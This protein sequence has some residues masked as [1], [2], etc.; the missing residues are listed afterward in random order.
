M[1]TAHS[2][3]HEKREPLGG[4]QYGAGGGGGGSSIEEKSILEQPPPPP[5]PP[6]RDPSDPTISAKKLPKKRKF[7]P[8]ELE[9]MD[10]ISNVTSNI[11]NMV[12]IRAPNMPLGQSGLVQQSTLATRQSPQQQ[13]SDCYQISSGHSVV[14]LPPQSTAVDYSLREEPL[15]SRPRPATVAIDLS[16]WRDHRVLALRDSY[17]YPGVIRNV[18]QG[19]I[20]IEF[21]GERKLVRYTDVLGTGRYDVIGDASPSVGQVTLDAKVCIRCPTSNNHIDAAKVFV[22][23]TVCKILTKPKRFVVKI[24][25]EDDQ[26][27][28]YV[29]K[30][31]DLRLV[32][33]PWWDE[34]EEGLEDCDSSRVEGIDNVVSVPEH[35]YRNSSEAPTAVP[36]LQL[37]HTS[38][39]T[40]HI[41]THSDTSGYY[42]TTGTSPLMTLGTS[43]HSASIALSNGN[44]P[45][46]DLESEDDLDR[47]DITFPSDAGSSKRS[48]MQSR[49]STSSLVEQRSITPRSQA[50]TPRS[51]AATPH[52]YKKGDVVATPSGVRKKFNGKQWRRLCSKEGCSKESQRRGYCS[53]HLSLKGSGL[54]GPTNTF[55]GGRMDGE[56]TSRD[57]DT[58]PNYGDR[59]IAGRF[60]QDETEAANMLV[61]LGSSRSA[62]PAF[63][64][65]TGQ[66]SISPCINQSPVPPLGLN[67][68]N[69]FMPISSPAHHAPPLISPGAKWKHSPTQS[70]FLTQYQQQVIKPEPNRVVRS[71]RPAPTAPVP[72]SIGTSVIRISPVSRGMPG[73]NLTLSWSEQSP[74][75]RHPSVVTTMAQQQ[76]QGIILQHA[77]TTNNSFPNHS[78]ISE[79]NSQIL[80]QSHSPHIPLSAPTPQN[81][82][83]LHKPL[84]Q[85]V[86]YAPQPQNQPIY[87]MQ[88]QHEKKYLVIK[89]SMDVATTGHITN[90]DDKYRSGLINHL[91]QLPP[92]LH[93]AQCQPPQSPAVSS[94]HI[95]KLSVLQQASKVATHV[96]TH[97]DMQRSQP[98]PTSVV[99]TT[100]TEAS[101]PPTP[102]SVFQ[103]VIVQP[104]HL[105]Q[106]PKTQPTREENS[107]NNG[108]LYGSHDVPPVYQP[109]PPSLLNN[110]V[111]NWK[112]AFSW[113]TTVLEQTEVSPPP[114][115]LSPPLSAPPIPISMST[116]GE[117][118]P[119]PGP[120]PITPAEEEDDD[121]F[122]A[123]P[124]TP[125]EVEANANKRRSQSLSALHSK[126]PQSPLKN[127]DR[128]RR[129]MN[130]FMI[131]SKR[132]RAVVHQRH[133]NQDNRTVSKILGEW[134]YAL[135]PEEKQKYHDLASEVKEAHF[136]AHPDWKWCS[137]DRRKSST[138]SFKGSE[139]RGK[140]NST[141]EE[142]DMGPPTDDVPLTPRATDEITVPVTT[143]YN[144][145]PTVEIINQSHTHRIMEIAVPVEDPEPDLKQE[146]DGNASDEDQMVI[147]E[148]PQPEI[149]LKC[150][151]KLTDS[152]N[153]VQD[154]DGEKKYAQPRFSPV[155]GQKR[156][157]TVKQEVT[158]RPKPI[159]AR[160]PSTGIETTTKYHHTPMDKGG[161]V[162]VLSSTY[163]YHSPVNPT[164][165]S[166]FQP[167]GGAFITMPIS[168][169]VIKPEPVKTEQQYSTQY[170]M[171][172]L[173][174]SI[175]ENGR[176]MPKFTAAP[177]LHSCGSKSMMALFKQQQ[178]L[179]SLGTILRPLTSAVPYQ[180]SFT[181]T[182]LDN[183]LVAVSKP[184][185]GSQ[186]LGPTPPHPR[187]YCGFH[188]PISDAGNRNIPAQGLVSGNK[189][190][191]QSVIVS[192]PYSVSTTSTTSTYRGIGHPIARLAEPEKNE[193][194]VGNN[195]AQFYV[196]N[197]KCEQDR[198]DTMS[199]LL[200]V[201]N[202]KH[203]QPSTPHTPHTP[204]NNHGS[205]D[206]STNKSYSMDEA[207]NN[208]IGP[209]K[210]PFMLAPTP[211]QLGRAPLQ[212]RQS[213]AMPPTSNA[214]DHGPLTSQ[215]CDNRTQTN[216][217][218][219]TEQMQQQQNF[220]E[221]HASPSPS[222]KKGSFFKKNVEDGM[223]RVLEQVNFQEKFSSLPEFKPEDIQSPSAISINT[224]GS[225][226]HGSVV[227]SGLHSSNLQSS[228]QM[229]NYRKKSV[230]GPHRPT[231]NE[232]DIESDVS[233]SATPKSTSSV[234]L[235]GNTFFG[236]DFNADMYRA[237]SDLVGDVDANSPRTPKTP[238]GG[239][240]NSVGIGRSENERGHRKVLE[241][242]RLLVM[243]LF[244]EN[245]YF[246]STQATT[247]FQA[248][249]SDI[250]PN[251]TSL[252]LKI[253]EVR[254]KL[255]ANSTPMSANSLVS[256]LPV[257]EPSPNVTGPLT[258]PPTSMG[259]PHSLPVSSSG[260]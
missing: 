40:S 165:V 241:Q 11:N 106:I 236:P 242:R 141:G 4:G 90:Q 60:D 176:N 185:Q 223:D 15:R 12:N 63:S 182:L 224:A 95:D 26:S 49:G 156:E 132:H 211:A 9:E 39:H 239:A 193:N 151:D 46:D 64:S 117:D 51:Q 197:I 238:G 57:S 167:T 229:Q 206:V 61:S 137:K 155:S 56:E 25:R 140:L 14:V 10:K 260:S 24:P 171:S 225:S 208:D 55:P 184:Q 201:T 181:L 3:M 121:V 246:P 166:G 50:A 103:H 42:R 240:V 133:P 47:E 79:Q 82:T 113:Q 107:K 62:T 21:D 175:H 153:D 207:Q 252:Q 71:N 81:L 256:P 105:V 22:K 29:V 233:V 114:S 58:S 17:Y 214:G 217:S 98:P 226:G 234:K 128:I 77:L 109:H 44:R 131:F 41:S 129:P 196:T 136:K 150:K 205:T 34:L 28:S 85:P 110:A 87:V 218:Q 258:A 89:N 123:E 112:K 204:L 237:N 144:E 161:A 33:P 102:T 53:R 253:R 146:E 20:Y 36:I 127:K 48:S 147:C 168:P 247:A 78:E 35:G 111:R 120:D 251:K 7:D 249:H 255:K 80:K 65:P 66:S 219:A 94:V 75:P 232:D 45:Y 187:M 97:M 179:Q 92:S 104:G 230:Q 6:Q 32:Q 122:E 93:Q 160:I 88:H 126:E 27:D 170:S 54:R 190:E 228:M 73:P 135:G 254:Q 199:I 159:K 8:S 68:N 174:A 257:S 125:A 19:E 38:H 200:P 164:G 138:T 157:I 115:A 30:R 96:S 31:A 139:S 245:G 70:T 86:D 124:T 216:T 59:R 91:G 119:G 152:D 243:Q 101:N 149:D 259:A 173:V 99:M 1:L 227:T 2:E 134:W 163:P 169:K 158:C 177:V 69:V 130:A 142:T 209:T 67:Q 186:Y 180:P 221:S 215:H 83:L 192:K 248:K 235:T 213:M 108:V 118:G 222:T 203:K 188:I 72:A 13:E 183:D 220:S 143:V 100:T 244:Q 189:L 191:T 162:S 23:G 145:V 154:E 148:D 52:R 212:R 195:H 194:Q 16:E 210:G 231:M 5:A 76:Q 74:P 202:D 250:F 198:K 37:H 116:P 43:A 172:N 84:E 178:P 18:V